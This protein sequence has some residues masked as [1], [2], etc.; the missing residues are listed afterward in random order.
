MTTS[1]PNSISDTEQCLPPA[2]S[3]CAPAA[4]ATAADTLRTRHADVVHR[5]DARLPPDSR[6]RTP[7]DALGPGFA[8]LKQ[9]ELLLLQHG[10]NLDAILQGV[11]CVLP[12]GCRLPDRYA[13]AVIVREQTY[14]GPG[15]HESLPRIERRILVNDTP[16]GCMQ[17]A[18]LEPPSDQHA[19]PF[20]SQE[21]QLLDFTA[22][23][24]SKTVERLGALEQLRATV[25]QLQQER[26]ALQQANAALRGILNQIEEERMA[27]GRSVS[28]NV[29]RLIMPLV[30][31]LQQRIPAPDRPIVE[32]LR[33]S[34]EEIVSPFVDR[35]SRVFASL[36][37]LEVAICRMIRDGLST[38]E[39]AKIRQV[40]AATVARQR[41][42]IRRKL[43]LAGTQTNLATFLRASME[44]SG[45]RKGQNERMAG[46]QYCVSGE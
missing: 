9:L 2:L 23:L 20:S 41:E 24:I 36:T 34:L 6:R 3:F 13:A 14:A 38:K 33:R 43:G 44:S 18:C 39:V 27:T 15:W 29:E 19:A 28:A 12:D 7:G 32:F 11:A 42:H 21:E 22:V 31:S 1:V 8:F 37:P 10:G 40:S 46:P 25:A 30:V 17:L 45:P 4:V 35:V 26:T 16:V 5:L